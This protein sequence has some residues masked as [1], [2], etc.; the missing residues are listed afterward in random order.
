MIIGKKNGIF[1]HIV[2]KAGHWKNHCPVYYTFEF[3]KKLAEFCEYKILIE[4]DINYLGEG[5]DMVA[6]SLRKT[7][8]NDFIS[9]AQFLLCEE[10]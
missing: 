8:D 7:T 2:P 5:K 3:F 9:P 4:E 6:V 10:K 1:I